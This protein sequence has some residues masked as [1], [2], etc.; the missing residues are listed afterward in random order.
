MWARIKSFPRLHPVLF[1]VG[2]STVK[3]SVSD[4]IVQKF[5]EKREEID[6][7]RNGAFALFGFFYLGG[8]QYA[9]YVPVFGRMFPQAASFATKP[10]RDKAK[11]TRGIFNV[12]AQTFL[13]QCVHH[14]LGYFPAFYITK[15]V[16]TR[17]EDFSISHALNAYQDNLWDDLKALWKIWVP[18]TLLNFA[19]SPMWLRIPVVA[20]TSLVWTMILSAMRG[21]SQIA[22][23]AEDEGDFMGGAVTGRT[24]AVVTTGLY[25]KMKG[26]S[27]GPVELDPHLSHIYVTASGPDKRGIVAALARV[28]SEHNGNITTSKMCR[29]GGDFTILM[30]VAVEPG[31]EDKMRHAL[32]STRHQINDLVLYTK[33]LHTDHSKAEEPPLQVHIN[34]FGSDRVGLLA[35]VTEALNKHELSIESLTTNVSAAEDLPPQHSSSRTFHVT[36]DAIG[37]YTMTKDQR[38]ALS[39]ELHGLKKELKLDALSVH[40]TG[41][42]PRVKVVKEEAADISAPQPATQS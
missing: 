32:G 38:R 39:E 20:T 8:V 3:T 34:C 1:G 21:S 16:V 9:L 31:M 19:F 24:L 6:W 41:K 40:V 14:P 13:D 25:K 11:D 30:H 26:H 5:V 29:L 4:L 12:F 22:V 17:R 2:Y 37:N 18:S 28:I 35:D 42:N 36:I 15:E 33:V 10:L 23:E 7:R 27:V